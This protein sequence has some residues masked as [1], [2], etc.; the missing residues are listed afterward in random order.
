MFLSTK[1]PIQRKK[2]GAEYLRMQTLLSIIA[3]FQLMFEQ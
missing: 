1:Y 2:N 3:D